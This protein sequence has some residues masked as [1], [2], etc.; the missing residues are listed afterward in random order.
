MGLI[1]DSDVYYND[2]LVEEGVV[3][4]MKDIYY[5][6]DKF[7]SGE[8]NLCFITGHSGSGKSTMAHGME[9]DKIE[10]YELDDVIYNKENFTMDELKKYG[11]LIYSFF[12]GPGKKYYFTEM[13]VKN[14]EAKGILN[15]DESLIRDFIKYS[16]SYSKS[17]K[18]TKYV[19]EGLWLLDFI[20]PSELKDYAVYIKGTSLV[21][22]TIRAANRNSKYEERMGN[23]RVKAWIGRASKIKNFYT[24]E[25]DLKKYQR[26][27]SS[28]IKKESVNESYNNLRY[29]DISKNK[30]KC[31]KYLKQHHSKYTNYIDNYNGEIVI[32]TDKDLMVGQ[33][34]VGKVGKDKGFITGL[35][36]RDS[37]RKMGIGSKLLDDA[38]KKY[39]GIDLTVTKDND[40]AIA[41]YKKY[42]FSADKKYK[43]KE[44]YWMK[45]NE[46]SK[47]ADGIDPDHNWS[48]E[49]NIESDIMNYVADS[50]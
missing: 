32:D 3:I 8:I 24:C 7:D 42:G 39:H 5:N 4:N 2:E 33:V 18:N 9:K 22:S 23:N 40:P 48:N 13:D 46:A 26:Y 16:K 44:Y 10:V 19:I 29:I 41:M 43:D 37:Y 49:S 27:F 11:D 17:H 35:W 15:Y 6:K 1:I 34:F 50:L 28:L 38:V 45:L 47:I 14:K 12:K 30:S 31:V 21:K 25:K 36:V 20:E